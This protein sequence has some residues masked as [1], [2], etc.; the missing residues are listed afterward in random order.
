M[1][2]NDIDKEYFEEI[3]RIYNMLSGEPAEALDMAGQL[4]KSDPDKAPTYFVV[5]MYAFTKNDY[6][7]AIELLNNAHGRDPDCREYADCL[8]ALYNVTGKL[9]DGLYFAKLATAL[10]S[11]PEIAPLVPPQMTNFFEAIDRI[12]ATQHYAQA[13]AAYHSRQYESSVELGDKEIRVNQDHDLC[14][15]VMGQS[16]LNL[17]SYNQAA[18]AFQGAIHLQPKL[19]ENYQFLG[20]AL[21][22][23]GKYDD[24]VASHRRALATD[25]T[26]TQLASAAVAGAESLGTEGS[27]VRK[28]FEKEMNKRTAG[29]RPSV[30]RKPRAKA[31]GDRIRVGFVSNRLFDCEASLFISALLENIDHAKFE[32]YVYQHSIGEDPITVSLKNCTDS[33]RQVFDLGDEVMEIIVSG[34]EIDVIVDL[35]GYTSENRAGLIAMKPAPIGIGWLEYPYGLGAPGIDYVLSDGV[36]AASDKKSLSKGQAAL[37]LPSGLFSIAPLSAMPQVSE[38]P[39]S[40][41]ERVTFGGSCDLSRLNPATAEVW[42]QVLMAVPRSRLL[43]REVPA[44]STAVKERA[45]EMFSHF[46]VADRIM[47]WVDEDG[48]RFQTD[49]YH[50]I[51]LLLDTAPISGLIDICEAMWMGVP[52]ISISGKRRA[53]QIGA[54]LLHSAGKPEWVCASP[55]KMVSL[56]KSLTKNLSKLADTRN[57]LREQVR[58]SNLFNPGLFAREMGEAIETA[59]KSGT[60]S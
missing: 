28:S 6:G 39:A 53:G 3:V 50:N 37:Q 10:D 26:S 7:R 11:R 43:L 19:A 51:D 38:L 57:G 31:D 45:V 21:Y 41:E 32:V 35:C 52:V 1:A 42:A 9:A 16:H 36:T 12:P 18:A 59:F 40:R 4:L 2:D 8:A 29:H 46:G 54:S 23:L 60:K 33:W 24:A 48:H 34:D 27:A 13:L 25:T 55:K 58:A 5:A 30:A 49:F 14:M 15:R 47:F 17:A 20:D 56:A 44:I 22:H